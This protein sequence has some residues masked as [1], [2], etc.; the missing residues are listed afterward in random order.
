M[1]MASEGLLFSDGTCIWQVA[2][3]NAALRES[4]SPNQLVDFLIDPIHVHL[5]RSRHG[6][7]SQHVGKKDAR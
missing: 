4:L 6:S 7:T 5:F 3:V 1:S 2:G